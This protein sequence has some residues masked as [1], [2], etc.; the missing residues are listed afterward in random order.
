M[1]RPRKGFTLIELLIVILIIGILVAL[2]LPQFISSVQKAKQKGTMQDMNSLAKALLDY[3]LDMGYAPEQNGAMVANSQF[4][5]AIQPFYYKV[6]PLADQWGTPFYIY[7][8]TDAVSG[9]GISGVTA[10]GSDDFLVVSYGRD[11]RQTPFSFNSQDPST[12]YFG[13]SALED[14][15]EDL[16]IWSGSWIHAPKSAQMGS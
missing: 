3:V 9:A 7:C 14:F 11:K 12:V 10:T 5:A 15:N 16:V 2:L 6:I 13:I 1:V 8:R 4:Y